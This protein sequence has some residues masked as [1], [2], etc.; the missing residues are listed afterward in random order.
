MYMYS[1]SPAGVESGPSWY[2]VV[3]YCWL[4]TM[5]NSHVQHVILASFPD[6]TPKLFIAPCIKAGREPGT[7][8]HATCVSAVT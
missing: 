7:F 4:L 1:M 3:S 2:T 8:R 5:Y 6:S